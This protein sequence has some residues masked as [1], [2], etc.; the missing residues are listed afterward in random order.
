M[1]DAPLAL[2]NSS[3]IVQIQ[4]PNKLSLATTTTRTSP[5]QQRSY[6]KTRPADFP[7]DV[8]RELLKVPIHRNNYGI[9]RFPKRGANKTIPYISPLLS[10]TGT[11]LFSETNFSHHSLHLAFLSAQDQAMPGA[12]FGVTV[13]TFHYFDAVFPHNDN[14]RYSALAPI[15]PRF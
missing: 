15:K 10:W 4:C 12:R 5:F 14:A 6:C 9:Q 11:F 1:L 8:E 2:S 3:L 13:R 7:N